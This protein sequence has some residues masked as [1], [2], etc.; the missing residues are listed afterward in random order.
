MTEFD[1]ARSRELSEL[2]LALATFALHLDVFEA[3]TRVLSFAQHRACGE[4]A[5]I[6]THHDHRKDVI[7]GQ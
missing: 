6:G 3:Q 5:L 1:E 4:T 7:R 2:R